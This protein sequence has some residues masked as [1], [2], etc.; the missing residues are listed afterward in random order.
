M[1]CYHDQRQFPPRVPAHGAQ[2]LHSEN[3]SNKQARFNQLEAGKA[4]SCFYLDYDIIRLTSL[5]VS[6]KTWT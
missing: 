3:I 5:C 4:S 2:S 1:R 6:T